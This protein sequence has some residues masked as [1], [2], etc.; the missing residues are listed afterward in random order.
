MRRYLSGMRLLPAFALLLAAVP[1]AAQD[2]PPFVPV[3]PIIAARSPLYAQ[4]IIGAA[5]GWRFRLVTDYSNVIE[6]GTSVDRREYL[7]DAELLQMDLWVTRDLSPQAFL[8]GDLSVRG[9]YDGHL[10]AFLNWYHDLIGLPVPARN[11]RPEDTFGWKQ[12]LPDGRVIERSRPGTFLGDL[13]VGAGVRFGRSQLVGT[14]TLPTA[15]ASGDGW[16]R[17]AVG[18]AGSLTSRL[19][20]GDRLIV[21]GGL[22]AGWTPTQGPLAEYQKSAFLGGMIGS[23]WRFSGS[24][25]LYATVAFQTA[26]WK[27]TGWSSVDGRDVT[28]DAGGLVNFKKGWPEVQIGITEDL[29]PRG[30]AVDVGFKVG[31][32]W[33]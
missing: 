10:D 30:P 22:S 27:G 7:L 21:D 8:L 23:R 13:R 2:L 17:K 11:R 6:T 9:G 31:L 15:S 4:P 5:P 33:R 1:L 3:N 18:V 20:Q 32:R 24:Q 19:A 28:L 12:T 26:N 14:V 16:G 25:S 29:A